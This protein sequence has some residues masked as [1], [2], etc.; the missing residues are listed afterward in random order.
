MIW[1]QIKIEKIVNKSSYKS[2]RNKSQFNIFFFYKL[3]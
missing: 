2:K 3:K 1:T